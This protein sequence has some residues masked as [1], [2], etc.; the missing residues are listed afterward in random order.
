MVYKPMGKYVQAQW[1][2]DLS[3]LRHSRWLISK[4]RLGGGL[5]SVGWSAMYIASCRAEEIVQ[6]LYA[7][8]RF[9]DGDMILE[10]ETTMAQSKL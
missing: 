6:L 7:R 2:S 4:D 8:V 3:A 10:P 1:H 5:T 9:R